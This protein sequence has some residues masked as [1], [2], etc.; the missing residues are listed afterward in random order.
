M[1]FKPDE[2]K[3][4]I[5]KTG[6]IA[7][8]SDFRVLVK[9]PDALIHYDSDSLSFRISGAEFPARQ[10]TGSS[11]SLYG[12]AMTMG[13]GANYAPITLEILMSPDM[14]ERDF[15][16]E[17]QDLI[18]GSHRKAKENSSVDSVQKQFNIGFYDEYISHQ[19]IT[20]QQF[21]RGQPDK[22]VYEVTLMDCF[23][24]LVSG[25]TMSWET[26]DVLKQQIQISYR[27]FVDEFS[28]RPDVN[29]VRAD[30]LFTRLNK[31]G[32]GGLINM[33]VGRLA[34]RVGTK[35]TAAAIFAAGK[36]MK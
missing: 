11:Y 3:A 36:L 34:E 23:P 32:A 25:S 2:F 21:D 8:A 24:S 7:L 4:E 17:W 30:S 27:Y 18:G 29:N 5:S 20:I 26:P 33:G 31:S 35:A 12:P 13:I 15:F 14:R 6:G 9:P 1:T 22:P 19:G 28:G 16:L 10:I